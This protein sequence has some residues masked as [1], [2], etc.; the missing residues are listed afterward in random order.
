MLKI[1]FHKDL[2]TI[3]MKIFFIYLIII[4]PIVL[5]GQQTLTI[6]EAV[7]TAIQLNFDIQIARNNAMIHTT[8]NTIGVAGGLPTVS[9]NT[10]DNNALYDL[11][12]KLSSGVDIRKNNVTSKSINT[13]ISASMVLFNGFKIRA[14]KE[15]LALLQSQSTFDLN[16]Q[17]QQTIASVMMIYYDIIRQQNYLNIIQRSLDVSQQKLNIT[18]ARYHVGMANDADVLQAQI[19]LNTAEQN[20]LSQHLTIDTEK[21]DLLLLMGVQQFYP[22][23]IHD[24]IQFD[25]YIQ[26]DTLC[27]FL[28]DNP[29]YLSANQQ[30]KINE[31]IVNELKAQRYPSIRLLTAY[32]F[33]Y[34][35]STAG[36]NLFTQ[37]YGPSI[38][39]TLQIPIF[40]GTI[41][42]TQQHIAS[43]NVK[44]AVL[45]QE[46]LYASL[47]ADALKTY[48]SYE[49][50]LR[51]LA[52]QQQNY[53]AAGKLVSIVIQQFELK[54]ATL[55]DVKTAQAS[56]EQVGYLLVNLQYA[57]KIADIELN[58]LMF[59]LK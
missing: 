39:A 15:K 28:K 59:R 3:A 13:G 56:F 51:Q 30:V 26:Q 23:E 1:L 10:T 14:T 42:S 24:S 46:N 38:G 17:I 2:R 44:N 27:N 36:F 16:A 54:Q 40:N 48:Q 25:R 5:L 12:Q 53:E 7:E 20:I 11:D 37:N 35:S 33:T 55:L 41:F 8:N 50:T 9:I 32:N 47:L 52:A 19:D 58:R 45:Q 21:I 18:Q 49:N 6:G 22:I 4:S 31:Q 43:Y 29:V 34:N 57:A